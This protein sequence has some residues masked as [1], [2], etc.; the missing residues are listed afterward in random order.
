MGWP[1]PSVNTHR[2]SGSSPT[3][4][5][6]ACWEGSP[7]G[8]HVEG[9]VIEIDAATRGAGLAAGLVQVVADGD[10]TAV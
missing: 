5:N 2:S 10:Q 9:G 3:A 7:A 8:E 6:S 4:P 1:S